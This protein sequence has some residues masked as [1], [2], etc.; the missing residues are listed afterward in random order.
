MEN[1]IWV[2]SCVVDLLAILKSQVTLS[3]PG[4]DSVSASFKKTWLVGPSPQW[5]LVLLDS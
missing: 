5:S 3:E 1:Q 2:A 4:L